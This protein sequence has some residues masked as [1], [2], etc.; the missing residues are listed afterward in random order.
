[1]L[2]FSPHSTM[3]FHVIATALNPIVDQSRFWL[4]ALFSFSTSYALRTCTRFYCTFLGG[5]VSETE[6]YP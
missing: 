6:R 5:R 1:M 3:V 4:E 2:A